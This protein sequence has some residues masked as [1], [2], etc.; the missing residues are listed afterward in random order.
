MAQ[1]REEEA[2]HGQRGEGGRKAGWATWAKRSNRPVG[3][4]VDWA[5]I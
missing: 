4:M 1:R 2:A 5:E 3:G